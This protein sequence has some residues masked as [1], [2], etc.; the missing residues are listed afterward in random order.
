MRLETPAATPAFSFAGDGFSK[1]VA[2]LTID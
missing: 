2:L 1:L